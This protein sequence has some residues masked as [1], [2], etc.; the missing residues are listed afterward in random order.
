M[1]SLLNKIAS[2]PAEEAV[3]E[4]HGLLKNSLS[5]SPQPSRRKGSLDKGD[6]QYKRLSK[7]DEGGDPGDNSSEQQE[8]GSNGGEKEPEHKGLRL[9][10]ATAI[11][12]MNMFGTGPFITFPLLLTT[13]KGPEVRRLDE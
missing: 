11:N 3:T 12:V 7:D 13:L 6:Q 8:E 9:F 2:K 10:Q 1:S 4:S 5:P